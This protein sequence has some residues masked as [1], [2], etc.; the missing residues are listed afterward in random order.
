MGKTEFKKGCTLLDQVYKE[1]T[2]TWGCKS[3][4][5]DVEDVKDFLLQLKNM[6]FNFFRDEPAYE[7]FI[8]RLN[9]IA[10]TK[11]T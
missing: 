5:L 3:G 11:F 10:G 4:V 7:L 9:E 6:Q 1:G 2:S 8:K